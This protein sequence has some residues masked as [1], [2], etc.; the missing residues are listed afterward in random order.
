MSDE[1]KRDF[2][3]TRQELSFEQD[4]ASYKFPEDFDLRIIQDFCDNYRDRE[5][6]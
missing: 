4:V 5:G 3:S 2:R 6:V 1:E